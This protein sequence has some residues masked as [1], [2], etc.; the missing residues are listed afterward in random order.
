MTR[1][2]RKAFIPQK[3]RPQV[4][5]EKIEGV[6]P[7]DKQ[8]APANLCWKNLKVR[9]KKPI[10]AI[11][12]I[13]VREDSSQSKVL[14]DCGHQGNIIFL[15]YDDLGVKW[16]FSFYKK[17]L[18]FYTELGPVLPIGIYNR[19]YCPSDTDPRFHIF[20]NFL[21]VWDVCTH[22]S[23]VGPRS[24]H[25]HNSSKPY[26]L[27]TTVQRALKNALG[28]AVSFPRSFCI[29][30]N[31]EFLK[32]KLEECG[33]LIVK[34]LSGTRSIVSSSDVFLQ[35]D[36]SSLAFLPTF[37]QVACAGPDI[38]VHWLD[39]H[40]YASVV[41]YKEGSIDFRYANKRSG[42]EKFVP[43][44]KLRLFVSH[45]VDAENL[46]LAGVDLIKNG[47]D[48]ICLECNPNPGWAGFH[49]STN[50]ENQLARKLI[51]SLSCP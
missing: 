9:R 6:P 18:I 22:Y 17:T 20:M 45:L 11:V 48:F 14:S 32:K 1:G 39:G 2:S 40:Y 30:G 36:W 41:R 31:K 5:G 24:I 7:C 26:Q 23:A 33:P 25:F 16:N 29:K 13:H 50:D 8:D 3:Y 27:I 12:C 21:S 15:H 19:P 43:S 35:W 28:S 51:R 38:R 44:K 47:R 49:R 42:Y 46:R 10:H 37:F 34:S 4:K